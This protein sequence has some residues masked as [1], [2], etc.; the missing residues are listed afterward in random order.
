VTDE[1]DESDE[2]HEPRRAVIGAVGGG[3]LASVGAWWLSRDAGEPTEPQSA[4]TTPTPAKTRSPTNTRRQVSTNTQTPTPTDT[5]TPRDTPTATPTD[6][7]TPTNTQTQT[8]TQTESPTATPTE[9]NRVIVTHRGERTQIELT[10]VWTDAEVVDIGGEVIPSD[11][12]DPTLL[13]VRVIVQNTSGQT[14]RRLG[15]LAHVP[16]PPTNAAGIDLIDD[17]ARSVDLNVSAGGRAQLYPQLEWHPDLD[18][19]EVSVDSGA[20]FQQT[21]TKTPTPTP[22]E[23]GFL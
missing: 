10:N 1:P 23:N 20:T 13:R 14:Y 8:P 16:N 19:V 5:Q 6:R 17:T 11:S 4:A 22:T 21:R 12:D 3:V 7:A 2:T 18:R 15:A 9:S